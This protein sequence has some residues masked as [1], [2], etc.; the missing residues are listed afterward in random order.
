M[1]PKQ[2]PLFDPKAPENIAVRKSEWRVMSTYQGGH[3]LFWGINTDTEFGEFITS[4]HPDF[5][6]GGMDEPDPDW[7]EHLVDDFGN[8]LSSLGEI[9]FWQPY[10]RKL[11]GVEK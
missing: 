7:K 5:H 8:R 9:H 10:P 3:A 6:Y 4:G 1:N 2:I 11:K